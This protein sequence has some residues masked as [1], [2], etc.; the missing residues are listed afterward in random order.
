MTA[1]TGTIKITAKNSKK[2][3]QTFV[4]RAKITTK[5]RHQITGLLQ[6]TGSFTDGLL[7]TSDRRAPDHVPSFG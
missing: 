4:N 5:S 6:I 2:T 7:S 1:Y 3:Q